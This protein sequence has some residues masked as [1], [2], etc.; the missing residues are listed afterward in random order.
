M[1]TLLFPKAADDF[2]EA[3]LP[4]IKMPTIWF[5][6]ASRFETVTSSGMLDGFML[7]DASTP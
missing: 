4:P 2:T 1:P 6:E 7:L 5:P 3:R